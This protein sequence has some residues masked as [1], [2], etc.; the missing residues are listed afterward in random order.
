EY[1][2]RVFLRAAGLEMPVR[3][4][5]LY[6]LG[7]GV[8]C[9]IVAQQLLGWPVITVLAFGIGTGSLAALYAPRAA[10]RRAAERAALPEFAE[11]LRA[12]IGA[13]DSIE[14]GLVKLA[15]T[16]PE[17]L[18]PELLRIVMRQQVGDFET[19]IAEFRDRLGDALAD[20]VAAALILEY[21][22]GGK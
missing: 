13:G 11:Q 12:S 18:R 10:R 17:A 4:F 7:C 14:Q 16:G 20:E 5:T 22:L 8:G 1:Q 19:A 21:R 2:L 6:S 15:A 3:T 9:G